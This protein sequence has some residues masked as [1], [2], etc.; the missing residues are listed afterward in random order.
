M[1]DSAGYKDGCFKKNDNVIKK[2]KKCIIYV[3]P[4]G[5]RLD[6]GYTHGLH[7]MLLYGELHDD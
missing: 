4:M 6:S 5:Q 7:A 3:L 2:T 1:M